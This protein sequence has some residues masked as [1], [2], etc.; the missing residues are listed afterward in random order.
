MNS[1]TRILLVVGL[2][3]TACGVRAEEKPVAKAADAMAA[4]AAQKVSGSLME[5]PFNDAKGTT[6][7]LTQYKGQV[8]MVVNVASKCGYTPQYT[9]L[10]QLYE[11]YRDK[12]LVIVAF[13]SNDYGGQEPGSNE[14]IQMFCKGKYN[15]T[16]P[17]K[18]KMPTRNDDKS[19][20]YQALTGPDSPYPGAIGWNFEKFIIDRQGKIVSR[21]KSKVTP[22][23]PEV[24][25]S[26]EK[27]LDAPK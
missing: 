25:A 11:K 9:E 1:V 23:S 14:D 21:F 17:V 16:F 27:A 6:E 8:I 15:V 18:G 3:M 22:M 2:L 7:T 24:I 4:K 12:G 19:P 5:I 20:L 26:V 13:P 10:E